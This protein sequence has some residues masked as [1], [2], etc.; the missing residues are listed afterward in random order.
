MAIVGSGV[1]RGVV[2]GVVGVVALAL[3][4]NAPAGG[5]AMRLGVTDDLAK[6]A[7]PA[8]AQAEILRA[9]AAGFDSIRLNQYWLPGQTEPPGGDLGLLKNAVFAAN[10]NGLKVVLVVSHPGSRTT[11]LTAQQRSEFAQFCATLAKELGPAVRVYTIGNE[12]NL[13]RFWLPQFGPNGEDVAAPA[14]LALLAAAYDALKAVSPR[15]LVLGGALSPRGSDNPALSR[16]THSPTQF[17]KDMGVAYRASGRTTPVM[18]ALSINPF[19]DNSSVS[20]ATPHPNST[21]IGIADYDKL[22]KLLADAF[23]G[24]AQPGSKLPIYYGEFGVESLPPAEKLSLYEGTEPTTT[25]PVDE[26]KQAEYYRKAIELSFCQPNVAGL[27]LF[28]NAD[29]AERTGWQSGVYYADKT[30]KTSLVEVKKAARQSRGGIVA[31]CAGMQL[32]PTVDRF[33]PFGSN[34]RYGVNFRCSIDCTAEVELVRLADR[35]VA[36]K[37]TGRAL[38]GVYSII[39]LPKLKLV[40]GSYQFNVS[41]YAPLNRGATVVRAT[42]PFG[43]RG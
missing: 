4:P 9:K 11:P 1:R 25:K 17:I 40:P 33:G 15:I 3:V 7:D 39:R 13:N 20:P 23:D 34:G 18:D 32:T 37:L 27:F 24:T 35:K 2:I 12:P 16:H 30:A 10:V 8:L 22:V 28:L 21:S 38:G 14:Y 31:K 29:D 43:V 42:R 41:F 19:A 26:K 5:P 36:G 6:Q